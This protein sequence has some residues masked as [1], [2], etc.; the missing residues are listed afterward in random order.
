MRARLTGRGVVL[1]LVLAIILGAAAAAGC[2]GNDNAS[3]S[4]S[5]TAT[6]TVASGQSADQIVKDSEAKMAT[7]NSAA[8][9]ADFALQ[10]QGDTSKMTDPTAKALLSQGVTFNAQG[11]SAK[12][13]AAADLT[14]TLGIA[15]QNLEFGMKAVGKKA[16]LQYQGA[17]YAVDAKNAKALDKQAQS[18][19][20]PTDQLKSL[21]IDPSTWGATYE[22]VGTESMDGVQ[23]YHVKAT[24]DPQKLAESLSK[25]AENP[26]L[27]QELGGASSGLGQLGQGLTQDK[28]QTEKLA[29]SLKSATVDY[30]IGVDDQYLYK[31]QFDAAMDTSGQQDMQGVD[32]MTMKGTV[33]MSDFDQAF[34]VSKPTGAKS[35][36]EFMN[37]L[38]GG[39]LGGSGSMSF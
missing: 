21:G 4:S 32:G 11:K 10:I 3:T 9:T 29:K 5:Q 33:S 8:F 15:G 34:E 38:F 37:Q 22:L 28:Q 14:M 24:A 16:W 19:A 7:V 25:A 1:L 13:P 35:F 18:G 2:G 23:V 31:A 6:T 20:S 30:W 36:K 27:N 12:K 26:K 17:W 39:M